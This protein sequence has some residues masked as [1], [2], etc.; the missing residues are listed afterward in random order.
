[1]PKRDSTALVLLWHQR[2]VVFV[3]ILL[4]FR[5]E[6]EKPACYTGYIK[7]AILFDTFEMRIFFLGLCPMK[8][9]HK[10]LQYA[11]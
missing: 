3:E 9:K 11:V 10:V 8:E 1:M 2:A 7:N 5:S 4:L 6:R